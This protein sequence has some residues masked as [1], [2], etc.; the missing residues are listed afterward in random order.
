ME[1]SSRETSVRLVLM[2]ECTCP[3]Y[4]TQRM[5]LD[6]AKTKAK[7]YRY[8]PW[9][10]RLGYK[11]PRQ[12][13][14]EEVH[15]SGNH[16]RGLAV[17]GHG[18]N[19]DGQ[20][21]VRHRRHDVEEEEAAQSRV[22]VEDLTF[23]ACDVD[24]PQNETLEEKPSV[25]RYLRLFGKSLFDSTPRVFAISHRNSAEATSCLL[26][27]TLSHH[28]HRLKRHRRCKMVCRLILKKTCGHMDASSSA[29]QASY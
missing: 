12:V 27:S 23:R 2:E 20:D 26:I 22:G 17:R 4:K 5:V 1:D 29:R 19:E 24:R 18:R 13:S 14:L 15:G 7:A 25:S 10:I 3:L 11:C 9:T 8:L 21:A 6:D 16:G 28:S